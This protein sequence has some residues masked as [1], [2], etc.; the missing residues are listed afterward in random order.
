MHWLG[1]KEYGRAKF[2]SLPICDVFTV[3]YLP[4]TSL[5]LLSAVIQKIFFQKQAMF[6]LVLLTR[7]LTQ[8]AKIS[9]TISLITISF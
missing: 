4:G 5:G 2:Q 9:K 6:K 8:E 3:S 7:P 1:K